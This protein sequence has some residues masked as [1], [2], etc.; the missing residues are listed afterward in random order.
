MFAEVLNEQP[1]EPLEASKSHYPQLNDEETDA[2]LRL[3]AKDDKSWSSGPEVESAPVRHYKSYF[4]VKKSSGK[5]C[6]TTNHHYEGYIAAHGQYTHLPVQVPKSQEL[7]RQCET[8]YGFPTQFRKPTAAEIKMIK[9]FI[10]GSILCAK[11]PDLL[12]RICTN[13][14]LRLIQSIIHAQIEGDLMIKIHH[15]FPVYIDFQ[16]RPR[17]IGMITMGLDNGNHN[18]AS[19]PAPTRY[20]TTLVVHLILGRENEQLK[21]DGKFEPYLSG[22]GLSLLSM[23]TQMTTMTIPMN[24]QICSP[25]GTVKL[26]RMRS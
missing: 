24:I 19:D 25:Y 2:L 11:L 5:P 15:E 4:Q 14:A 9:G 8:P 1:H 10:E 17:L 3:F 6:R 12:K 26:V 18:K 16:N 13:E 22:T 21:I 23:S 7:R 20:H